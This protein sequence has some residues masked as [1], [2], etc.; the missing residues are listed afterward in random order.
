MLRNI[1]GNPSLQIESSTLTINLWTALPSQEGA[2]RLATGSALVS[3]VY[4]G[5]LFWADVFWSPVSVASGTTYWITAGLS[6]PIFQATM[7]G[8]DSYSSGFAAASDHFHLEP[9]E[10]SSYELTRGHDLVF[11]TYTTVPEP[12]TLWLVG[13]GLVGLAMARRRRSAAHVD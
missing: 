1:A 2:T 3:G 12:N 9:T 13:A 11:R 7:K 5:E 6:N 10:S 8:D 4:Y